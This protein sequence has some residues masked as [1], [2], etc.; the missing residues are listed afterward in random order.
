MQQVQQNVGLALLPI[1]FALSFV[2]SFFVQFIF[3]LLNDLSALMLLSLLPIYAPGLAQ[4]IQSTI[5]GLVQL[6]LLQTDKW[7]PQLLF[8]DD[9]DDGPLNECFNMGGYSSQQ[10]LLNAG[11]SFVYLG[12]IGCGF[13]FLGVFKIFGC[14]RAYQRFAAFLKWNLVIRFILQQLPALVMAASINTYSFQVASVSLIIC[15]VMSSLVLASVPAIVWWF[16]KTIEKCVEDKVLQY[17]GGESEKSGQCNTL[18]DGL[19]LTTTLGRHWNLVYLLRQIS[20]VFILVFLRDHPTFQLLLIHLKQITLQSSILHS[21]PLQSQ[22]ENRVSLFN[23]LM[24]SAYLYTLQCLLMLIDDDNLRT[25]LGWALLAILALTIS[26]NLAKTCLLVY[27]EAS[28]RLRRRRARKY[29]IQI[30]CT[31]TQ[32]KQPVDEMLVV[33]DICAD[34]TTNKSHLDLIREEIKEEEEEEKEGM[35]PQVTR[36]KK[37]TTRRLLKRKKFEA[38]HTVE[39]QC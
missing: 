15:A 32:S 21:T 3:S 24:I 12:I 1:S 6:D 20:L 7:V 18:T 30:T 37:K 13:T 27:Q 35:H 17:E 19:N 11:S 39:A 26:A 36:K 10:S 5:L 2:M 16:K 31:T 23:E 38:P 4:P 14:S 25:V 29:S 33:Q 34:A 22:L 8:P 28:V 9:A